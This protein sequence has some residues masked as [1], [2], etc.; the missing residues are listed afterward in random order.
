MYQQGYKINDMRVS[1]LNHSTAL[2]HLLFM[3]EIEHETWV[4]L[5]NRL[6]GVNTVKHLKQSSYKVPK[7]LPKAFESW[8]EYRDY[9]VD[10][11]VS[12]EEHKELFRNKFRK[13]DEKY[14]GMK[15][16]ESMYKVQITSV[17]TNGYAMTKINNWE[18][19]PEVNSFRKWKKTGQLPPVKNKYI[20]G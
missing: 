13:M 12:G 17:L 9:L 3:Q 16:A 4:K 20:H 14:E 15:N 19:S 2:S 11:L 7:E 18:R 10:N 6:E 8:P 5:S 1:N